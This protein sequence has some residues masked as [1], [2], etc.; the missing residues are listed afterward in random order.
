MSAW[1][2]LF[3]RAVGDP[4]AWA[5]QFAAR[6]V[7]AQPE[8]A[9]LTVSEIAELAVTWPEPKLRE[10]HCHPRVTA[11]LLAV[12]SEAEPGP[13]GAVGSLT[14]IPVIEHGDMPPGAWEL[15]ENGEVV[16]SGR[17]RTIEERAREIADSLSA[18]LPEG[19]RFTWE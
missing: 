1:E 19:L 8:V 11:H 4:E 18:M 3:T 14:G 13:P 5:A 17:L 15:R 7:T 6:P 9:A 2:E 16:S 12:S 10:L